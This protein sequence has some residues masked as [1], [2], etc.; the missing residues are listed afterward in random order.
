MRS[1]IERP[2]PEPARRLGALVEALEL[3]EHGLL[4]GRR[5]AEAGIPDLDARSPAPAPAA[6]ER[7]GPAACT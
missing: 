5:D 2:R 7:R 6:D 3:A 1:T 4:L